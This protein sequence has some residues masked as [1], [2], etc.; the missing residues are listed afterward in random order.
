M[1]SLSDLLRPAID[2]RGNKI[3]DRSEKLN[4]REINQLFVGWC[5][6]YLMLPEA[7]CWG[8]E[9]GEGSQKV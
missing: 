3:I 1:I 8:G 7:A 5:Y 6:N 2:R 9:M 4:V